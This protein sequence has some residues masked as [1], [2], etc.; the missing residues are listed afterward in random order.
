MIKR[1]ENVQI[2][3]VDVRDKE[4]LLNLSKLLRTQQEREKELENQVG[5][6]K[7][8]IL[9]TIMNAIRLNLYNTHNTPC[10]QN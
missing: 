3:L 2:H 9:S 7:Y 10:L 5:F 8:L 1:L 4:D 6:C